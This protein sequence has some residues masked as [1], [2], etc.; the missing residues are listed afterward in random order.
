[1]PFGKYS[2]TLVESYELIYPGVK[3]HTHKQQ[4]KA[5]MQQHK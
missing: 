5:K 3:S 4:R 2:W 1:M